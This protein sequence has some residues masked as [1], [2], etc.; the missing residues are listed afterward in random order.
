MT[1]NINT[2]TLK[3]AL[4][5][6]AAF[7]DARPSLAILERVHINVQYGS[8]RLTV[9]DM[10]KSLTAKVPIDGANP[11]AV[12]VKF[13]DLRKV[14][15]R[16]KSD[17]ISVDFRTG[18]ESPEVMIKAGNLQFTLNAKPG[19]DF[20]SIPEADDIAMSTDTTWGEFINEAVFVKTAS[21]M[22]M[23]KNFTSGILFVYRPETLE[24]V[25]TDGHRLH[26]SKIRGRHS[27]KPDESE[28]AA[29]VPTGT[30][31]AMAKLKIDP[32]ASLRIGFSEN[33]MTWSVP[34]E[35]I[36]GVSHLLDTPYPDY[37][38]VIPDDCQSHFRLDTRATIESLN[39]LAVIASERDGRDMVVVNAN[40]TLNLSAHAE[41][42][43]SAE[44]VVPCVHVAGPERRFALNVFYMIETLKLANGEI[45]LS[46][47]GG[48]EPARF[49]YPDTERIAV[50]MPVRLPE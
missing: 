33:L 45:M 34:S 50:V 40:G 12:A 5:R 13:K 47:N 31:H 44:A 28:S 3:A 35:G 11:C 1:G 6:L 25:G 42:M 18:T 16:V 20:P 8:A 38:K 26:L 29:L 9:Y 27:I 2:Q 21:S 19:A 46:T 15:D 30:I 37:R 4:K 32:D 49:D 41:S 7:V 23:P 10:E 39:A 24:L 48:L 36:E 22:D 17:T 43:G 14:I